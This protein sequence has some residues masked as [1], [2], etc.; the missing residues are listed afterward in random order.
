MRDRGF[1]RRQMARAKRRAR[2][3]LNF[4]LWPLAEQ[5]PRMVGIR[6]GLRAVC[7]CSMCGNPRRR[8][9]LPT[10][11]ELQRADSDRRDWRL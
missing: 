10:R 9:G 2:R 1:R 11:Q 7:S 3:V 5:T 8:F 6:A 4:T